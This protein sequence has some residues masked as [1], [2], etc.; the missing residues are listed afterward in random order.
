MKT[1]FTFLNSIIVVR[2]GCGGRRRSDVLT[3]NQHHVGDGTEESIEFR[4][5]S[6][7]CC[8]CVGEEMRV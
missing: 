8:T 6:V 1:G 2:G 5:G 7:G 3:A 4:A